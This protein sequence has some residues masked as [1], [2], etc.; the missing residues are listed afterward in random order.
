MSRLIVLA[1]TF[2][3]APLLAG[4]SLGFKK[5]LIANTHWQS[6]GLILVFLVVILFLLAKYTKKTEAAGQKCKVIERI[7]VQNKTKMYVIDYQGQQFL[8]AE[9]PNAL[10]I[11]PLPQPGLHH[12]A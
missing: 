6:Y 10:A 7:A 1:L 12:G 2:W 11:H 9:N 3:A 5:E 4:E 8:L